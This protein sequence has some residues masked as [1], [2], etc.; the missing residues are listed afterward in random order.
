MAQKGRFLLRRWLGVFCALAMLSIPLVDKGLAGVGLELSWQDWL[1]RQRAAQQAQPADSHARV[2]QIVIIDIDDDSLQ[3]MAPLVGKWPWPR[4]VH[5][6]LLEYLLPLEPQ[7]DNNTTSNK[8]L[9]RPACF[10]YVILN[11]NGQHLIQN[12]KFICK[13]SSLN[14]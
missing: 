6:E 5:A 13:A 4:S 10:M 8:L 3:A 12:I 9:K 14:E 11:L 1:V 2:D 7:A